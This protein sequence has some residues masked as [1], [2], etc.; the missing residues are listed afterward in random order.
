MISRRSVQFAGG[1]LRNPVA[2]G[3]LVPSSRFLADRMLRRV[4]WSRARVVV[5]L[6]P[7]PGGMTERILAR[8]HR[9]ATLIAIE[10]NTRFAA[11]L[12]ESLPDGR[13]RVVHGSAAQL[14]GA[15]RSA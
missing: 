14:K 2:T 5:E 6:G 1:F 7:G 10:S 13:L 9:D 4:A 8:M 15:L 3:S 11:S 12:R